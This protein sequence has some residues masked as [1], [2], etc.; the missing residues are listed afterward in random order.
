MNTVD[1]LVGTALRRAGGVLR[2]RE[3]EMDVPDEL[4]AGRFDFTQTLRI[5]VNLLENAAK[6]SPRGSC[7]T[8][9]SPTWKNESGFAAP[10]IFTADRSR[11]DW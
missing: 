6:F 8:V 4:L 10:V 1:D 9:R 3:V 11:A 7:A 2:G 5:L